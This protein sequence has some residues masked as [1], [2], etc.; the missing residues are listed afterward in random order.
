MVNIHKK[1]SAYFHNLA[2]K[3]ISPESS[4]LILALLC[5]FF[6]LLFSLLMS[7]WGYKIAICFSVLAIILSFKIKNTVRLLIIALNIVLIILNSL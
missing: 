7:A 4:R 1:V 6:A 3:Q 5:T 2:S